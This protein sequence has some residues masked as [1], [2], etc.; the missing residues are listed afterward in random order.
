[1]F[2]TGFKWATVQ[3]LLTGEEPLADLSRE[4]DISPNVLRNW[5]R[6]AE[7]GATTAVQAS[8]DVVPACQ[9]REAYEKIRELE[10]AL[11]RKTMENEILRAAQ[12]V[13]KKRCRCAE[14][15]GDDGASDDHDLRGPRTR[16][17]HR[18]LPGAS[19]AERPPPASHRRHV[20]AADSR[21]DQEPGDLRLP[22][23]VG[24]GESHLPDG[25]QPQTDLAG[26]AVARVDA[27]V[28]RAPTLCRP[29]LGQIQQPASNQRWCSD[30]FLIPCWS[31]AFAIDCHDREVSAFV[32][33]P[34]PLTAADIRTLMDHM[35]WARFGEATLTAPHAIQWL[36]DNGSEF[37]SKAL[38][39]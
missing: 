27:R 30:V 7:A 2:S 34:R 3:R 39:H 25:L 1:V 13:V 16:A 29:H 15:P 9:L 4:L 22:P 35:L 8:E 18:L 19:A 32:A 17:A 21:G 31:G 33:S 10:L 5:K 37:T 14:S 11:G 24:H 28:A 26:N 23:S 36:S 20:P 38:D 12:E 6:F